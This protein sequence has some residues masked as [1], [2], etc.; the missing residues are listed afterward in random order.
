[1]PNS[2]HKRRH[3]LPVLVPQHKSH[4][5]FHDRPFLPWHRHLL[6]GLIPPEVV[7]HVSGTFCKG[8]VRTLS[9]Y[10]PCLLADAGE[11]L[12]Y[13]GMF[14]TR[15]RGAHSCQ[16]KGGHRSGHNFRS[17]NCRGPRRIDAALDLRRRACESGHCRFAAERPAIEKHRNLLDEGKNAYLQPWETTRMKC[18][19]C[20]NDLTFHALTKRAISVASSIGEVLA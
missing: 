8:R 3:A 6:V 10:G 19:V 4:P 9:L 11:T 14:P 15:P 2:R 12:D 18:S 5:F 20:G 13:L 16:F 17:I 1:M 7:N